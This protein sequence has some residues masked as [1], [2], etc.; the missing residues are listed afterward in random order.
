VATDPQGNVW[1]A[2][3]SDDLRRFEPQAGRW[4]SLTATGIGFNA[5]D[6][7]YQG[8]YL[9]D[10]AGSQSGAIWVADCI[11]KGEGFDG[12]G[13]RW[14]KDGKWNP[15]LATEGN[16]VFDIEQ[17]KAGRMWVGAPN[18]LLR[19]DPVN[20]TW[21]EIPLPTWERPQIVISIDLDPAGD[22]WVSMYRCGGASCSDVVT[23]FL[24]NDA[25]LP[26]QAEG[27]MYM[28]P[29]SVA[30]SADGTAWVCSEGSVYHR[31]LEQA[32][33][34]DTLNASACVIAVDGAGTVWVGNA[35]G[36]W[37]LEP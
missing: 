22:P 24:K 9:A 6:P 10:V 26:L 20:G 15:I 4:M 16:C 11:G 23:Y 29:P 33:L 25:W 8:H 32:E 5:A 34:I 31:T 12:Q 3:G 19:Y 18:A 37:K 30:F 13:V 35:A 2:T 17:D 1:L 21:T 7:D 14:L 28:L 27:V 36:L